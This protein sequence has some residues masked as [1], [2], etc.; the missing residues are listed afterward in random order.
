MRRHALVLTWGV[1]DHVHTAGELIAGNRAQLPALISAAASSTASTG[2]GTAVAA[3]T[4]HPDEVQQRRQPYVGQQVHAR[5]LASHAQEVDQAYPRSITG[6]RQGVNAAADD[7]DEEVSEAA[8]REILQQQH[9]L[10]G[11]Y[12]WALPAAEPAWTT[13]AAPDNKLL[14]EHDVQ[15]DTAVCSTSC[16]HDDGDVPADHDHSRTFP[17]RG[18][19]GTDAL[20]G[21]VARAAW[22]ESCLQQACQGPDVR[23]QPCRVSQNSTEDY[24]G[25]KG[26]DDVAD[27]PASAAASSTQTDQEQPKQQRQSS[28]GGR[29][30][31]T[32]R[33]LRTPSRD[34]VD[35]EWCFDDSCEGVLVLEMTDDTRRVTAVAVR[36]E[37]QDRK[38][39]KVVDLY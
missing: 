9:P 5:T 35:S 13:K 1:G 36:D 3:N 10:H 25:T 4:A 15:P 11:Y 29:F 8:W 7:D 23:E 2:C 6:V 31:R 22:E 33:W 17:A 14:L 19:D 34:W 30:A 21:R 26:L 16:D 39:C 37:T 27:E 32:W 18:C 20:G 12:D 24:T 28:A 38:P